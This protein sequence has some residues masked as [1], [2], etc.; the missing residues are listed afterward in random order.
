MWPI[1]YCINTSNIADERNWNYAILTK[2]SI[3]CADFQ[4]RDLVLIE[5]NNP[6]VKWV[7]EP[8]GLKDDWLLYYKPVTS[9]HVHKVVLPFYQQL[10][11][12]ELSS[13]HHTPSSHTHESS[14]SEDE[15]AAGKASASK[16]GDQAYEES[17]NDDNADDDDDAEHPSTNVESDANQG[18]GLDA[19]RVF[20]YDEYPFD[21]P[22][23]DHE[24][25]MVDRCKVS[26]RLHK[27]YQISAKSSSIVAYNY[28]HPVGEHRTFGEYLLVQLSSHN[29]PTFL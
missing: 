24:F 9:D 6:I 21:I 3:R 4:I 29:F 8:S 19:D 7:D 2:L 27:D 16:E 25:T 15:S 20:G 18:G 28:W 23:C 10:D 26:R 13:V 1:M 5:H 22:S 14:G 17:F 11:E 12:M